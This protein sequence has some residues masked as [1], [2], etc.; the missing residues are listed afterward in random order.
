MAPG[1]RILKRLPTFALV[2]APTLALGIGAVS[3][4][5]TFVDGVLLRPLPYPDADRL[6]VIQNG[7]TGQLSPWLSPP[8]YRDLTTDGNVFASAAALSPVTANLLGTGEPR[9]VHGVDVTTDFFAV[10]GV[11]PRLG[12]GFADGDHDVVVMSDAL[13]RN[14]FGARSDIV[15]HTVRLD[16]RPHTVVGVAEAMPWPA[17]ADFWRP[18]VFSPEHLADTRRGAQ[19]VMA[20]GRLRPDLDAAGANDALRPVAARLAREFP[21]SNEARTA[22]VRPLH[23]HLVEDIRPALLALQGAVGLVL[24]IACV[25]VAGLLLA[26]SHARRADLAIH[27]ALGASRLQ[28]LRPLVRESLVLGL[29]SAAGGLCLAYA[30]TRAAIRFAPAD[31][32]RAADIAVDLRVAAV[33]AAAALLTSVVFGIVP[34]WVAA[35]TSAAA[36]LLGRGTLAP[37]GAGARRL[38]VT[39]ELALA[40][41]LLVGAGLLMRSYHHVTGIHPG[42]ARDHVLTFNLALPQSAYPSAAIRAA[43][44]DGL[45]ERLAAGHGAEA[46][47]AVAGLPL[48][49]DFNAGTSFTRAG[50][51]HSAN[52]PSAGLR[53]VTPRYFETLEIPVRRGRAFHRHDDERGLEVAV[54][55]EEAARRYWPAQDPVGQVIEIGAQLVGDVRHG[56]KTIVGVVGDVRHDGLEL[57]ATPEVYLP[58]AQHATDG[59]TVVV[60]TA[61]HPAS[62]APAARAA[63]RAADPELPLSDVRTMEEITAG[64]FARRR[65][66]MGLLAAFA[67]VAVAL[68]ASGVY[69]LLAYLV[70][71]R[72]REIGLRVAVGAAPSDVV[73]DWLREGA[74]L[75]AAGL[76]LGLLA[77][78]AA[79]H[80]LAATLVGVSASD[81]LA[82]SAAAV[83]LLAAAM[84]ASVVPA[85]RAA[86]LDPLEAL[87]GD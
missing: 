62:F 15:G 81:P 63:V 29:A 23:D 84:L 45:L 26:R 53:L 25:N 31:L 61:G 86:H 13:W 54:I 80:V 43:L 40:T 38:L 55:N 72:R 48:S 59:F 12:R 36:S 77:A 3:T 24:L 39:G 18:L 14:A 66:T 47:A 7:P 44:V 71:Q 41:V 42:F 33:A 46:A 1:V 76:V 69:A 64:S 51:A 65:F 70:S 73:R 83:V 49:G 17:Q 34:A 32:P 10:L 78:A 60:R 8:N 4:I 30:A 52:A 2:A 21:R 50:E 85:R 19:W 11:A 58:Y 87:R 75:A 57:G 27:S 6:V 16:G 79:A 35:R 68:G 28:L 56:P 22:V 74:V 67:A 82:Y 37:S 20:L 5:F 9:R